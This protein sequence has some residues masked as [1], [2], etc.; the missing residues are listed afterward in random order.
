MASYSLTGTVYFPTRIQNNSATAIDNIFL[1][2]SKFDDYVILPIVN[3]LSDHNAKLFTINNIHLKVLVNTLRFIR[4]FNKQGILDFGIK[5]SFETWDNVFENNDMNSMYNYFLNAYLRIFYSSF[6][7]KKL[8]T[9]ANGNAWIT[10]GI[11]S[12]CKP[13]RELY[14]LYKNSNDPLLKNRYKLYCRILS[15]VIRE[16]KKCYFS[17]Q[18]ETSKNKMKTIWD[19]TRL[20]TGIRTKNDD[21]H[22]LNTHNNTNNDSQTMPDFLNKYFLSITGKNHNVSD[23]N[24]NS[25]DYLNLT[26][27]E[28]YPDMKYQYTSTVEVGKIISSLKSK[29]LTWL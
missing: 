1:N 3:G 10:T 6:P 23:K 24:D 20:L 26:C 16:A 4:K 28:P 27:N 29:K 18:V 14:S 25:A 9:K 21:I 22:Q 12:S 5:L 13:K 17:K 19:I 7:L 11:K 2:T 8:V 15:N